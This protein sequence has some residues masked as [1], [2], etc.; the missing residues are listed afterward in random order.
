MEAFY[1]RREFFFTALEFELPT[2]G[3]LGLQYN[4]IMQNA[5]QIFVKNIYLSVRSQYC[6]TTCN[7]MS[8]A[9]SIQSKTLS[10][11]MPTTAIVPLPVGKR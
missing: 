11:E 7:K 10:L 4:I 2:H 6:S 9:L 5:V 3:T 1:S 8:Q